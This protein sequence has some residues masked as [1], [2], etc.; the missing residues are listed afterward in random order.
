MAGIRIVECRSV[1]LQANQPIFMLFRDRIQPPKV[2]RFIGFNKR[3][4]K[5]AMTQHNLCDQAIHAK[6]LLCCIFDSLSKSRFPRMSIGER[7]RKTVSE[8]TD[9]NDCERVNLFHLIRAFEAAESVPTEFEPILEWA[10]NKYSREFALSNRP[11]SNESC[12]SNDPSMEIVRKYWPTG[13]CG[14]P[15]PIGC[16]RVDQLQH[17]HLLWLYRNKMV[18]EYRIPGL[19][20][21][22]WQAESVLENNP[23]LTNPYYQEVSVVEPEDEKMKITNRWEL[24][25]PTDFFLWITETAIANIA[26]F[27]ERNGSS[28]FAAYSEGSYWI[29]PFNEE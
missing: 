25:Y 10:T 22:E 7:F 24:V 4:I 13:Q 18:H 23:H 21:E 3:M 27:H 26:E 11:G 19:W 28:P 8:Y 20:R 6:V 2:E 1:S 16:T 17:K 29:P 14:E 5:T 15:K 12:I 9:W